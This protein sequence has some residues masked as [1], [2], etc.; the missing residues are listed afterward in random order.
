MVYRIQLPFLCCIPYTVYCIPY[1]EL[2]TELYTKLYTE[3]YKRNKSNQKG[4]REMLAMIA[5]DKDK[6]QIDE[7]MEDMMDLYEQDR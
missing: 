5:K 2:Y 1:T 7:E 4:T 3:L 6:A